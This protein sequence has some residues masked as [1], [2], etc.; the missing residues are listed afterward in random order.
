[1]LGRLRFR[2]SPDIAQPAG[3]AMFQKGVEQRENL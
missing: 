3:D 2:A 1:M